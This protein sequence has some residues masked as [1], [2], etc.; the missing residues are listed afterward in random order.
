MTTAIYHVLFFNSTWYE[1][2]QSIHV[3]VCYDKSLKHATSNRMLLCYHTNMYEHTHTHTF[4]ENHEKGP[5]LG[6]I[7]SM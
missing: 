5:T 4:Q 7:A 3:S 1:E 6:P 2:R